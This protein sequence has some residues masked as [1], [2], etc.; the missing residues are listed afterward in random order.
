MTSQSDLELEEQID[1]R[2][3]FLRV[4]R[5]RLLVILVTCFGIL[6]SI[7]YVRTLPNLYE[8]RAILAPSSEVGHSIGQIPQLGN[9]LGFG[10]SSGG[11]AIANTVLAME[12]LKS[13]SFFEK[14]LYERVIPELAAFESWNNEKRTILYNAELYDKESGR[15]AQ[16]PKSKKSLKPSPQASHKS[17][18]NAIEVGSL[19]SGLVSLRVVHQSPLIARDWISLVIERIN[20]DIR[21]RDIS[22]ARASLEFLE[23]L[24]AKNSIVTLDQVFAQLIEEETKKVMLG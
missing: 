2:E 5:G 17:F 19:G 12:R 22:Q 16:D 14:H 21:E 1:L 3:I 20:D 4:W 13:L 24:L 10:S 8:S 18:V 7:F 6:F 9:Y 11:G 23:E 15:W